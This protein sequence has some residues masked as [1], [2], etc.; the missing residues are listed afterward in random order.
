MKVR[1]GFVAN[2]SSS[3]FIVL[4]K[5]AWGTEKNTDFIATKEDILKLIEYGFKYTDTTNPFR[6]EELRSV[7]N[8]EPVEKSGYEALALAVACNESDVLYFLVKNNIPFKASTHYQNH[9]YAYGRGWENII[10]AE[11]FGQTMC[12]YGEEYTE[13]LGH[14]ELPPVQKIPRDKWLKGEE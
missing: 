6:Y 1:F 8:A 12:M 3:S 2:S 10:R 14:W 9:Y 13:E 5:D 11:N 4:I 7:N